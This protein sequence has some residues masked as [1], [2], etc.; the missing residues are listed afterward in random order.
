MYKRQ[1]RS[2]LIDITLTSS[3]LGNFKTDWKVTETETFSDH[4]MIDFSV[5]TSIPN[6]YEFI[7]DT[8]NMDINKFKTLTENDAIEILKIAQNTCSLNKIELITK[9][10]TE[11][12]SLRSKQS[13]VTR[14]IK[15]N[16]MN[17]PWITAEFK[18]QR[19]KI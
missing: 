9:L 8:N 12:F 17:N 6:I 18:K 10:I 11:S 19:K 15:Q 16:G 14:R 5:N 13:S 3:G 4:R 2:S 7:T 1:G